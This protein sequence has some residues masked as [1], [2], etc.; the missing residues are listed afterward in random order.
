MAVATSVSERAPQRYGDVIVVGGGCYGGYYVRQLRRAAQAGAITWR[1]LLVV[2][3][4]P[5]CAVFCAGGDDLTMIVEEWEA[6][7]ARYLADAADDPVLAADA[8]VVPSPLMPHLTFRWLK[9]RA[10]ARWPDQS[11]TLVPVEGSLATPWERDGDDGTRYASFATW[12]CPINCIEPMTCPHTRDAR[13]WSLPVHLTRARGRQWERPAIFLHT[14]HRAYG[15]GMFDVAPLLAGDRAIAEAGPGEVA[16]V[17]A[18]HCH[19]AVAV[20]RVGPA[21]A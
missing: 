12:M 16:V 1:R 20:L 3:R 19:G 2:D 8:A 18:S 7:F 21:P 14:S 17:S 13:D 9:A 11:V 15:V 6:F 10:E 4:D 5:A